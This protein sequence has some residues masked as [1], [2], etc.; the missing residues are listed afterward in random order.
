MANVIQTFPRGTGG[1]HTILDNSGT[2]VTDRKEM[3]FKGLSVSDNPTDEVTEVEAVGLNQDSLDDIANANISNAMVGSGF[4]YST[5]EQ[6]I[7]RWFDGLPLYQKVFTGT[8]PSTDGHTI[9]LGG[10]YNIKDMWGI[11]TRADGGIMPIGFHYPSPSQ[12]ICFYGV[13]QSGHSYINLFA[14]VTYDQ[15]RPFEMVVTYTK[16]SDA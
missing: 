15:G 3:Q 16:D 5:S 4:N 9:D 1:G 13:K 2:A 8:M 6:C 11:V 7:G 14:T 12:D 10:A